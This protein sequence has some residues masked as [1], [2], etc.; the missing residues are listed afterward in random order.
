V[1]AADHRGVALARVAAT[2]VRRMGHEC[3]EILPSG[4]ESVDYPDYAR[5]VARA[6]ASG[7]C[8]LGI[9]VCHTG[10]GMSIAA[11]KI[12]GVRAAR[13]VSAYDVEM[14][15]RHNQA[16]VLCLGEHDLDAAATEKMVATW[17]TTAFEG[18]RHARRV[19]KM[20]PGAH[21][22]LGD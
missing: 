19:E 7:G 3:E 22:S 16:N 5:P 18:G 9:L 20:E 21:E 13:C 14:A 2:V 8:D 17:L 11:N 12:P 15:R 1:I 10:I 6:V 4:A